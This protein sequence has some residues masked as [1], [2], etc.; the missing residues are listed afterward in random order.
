MN[1]Y[2][3]ALKNFSAEEARLKWGCNE[4]QWQAGFHTTA[5]L[6]ARY[7]LISNYRNAQYP[8]LKH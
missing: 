4:Y 2:K 1:Y 8:N 5:A 7:N 6:V 3:F